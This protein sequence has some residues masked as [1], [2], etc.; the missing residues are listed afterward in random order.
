MARVRVNGADLEVETFGDVRWPAILLIAGSNSSM[1]GWEPDFCRRLAAGPRFVIRYDH[2][3]TGGSTT[4]PA[5]RP[6]Y[7]SRELAQDALGVLD[8]LGVARAHL[9]GVSMGGAIAQL[10]ALDHPD[11][12]VALTLIATSSG[13][14]RIFPRWRRGCGPTS[15]A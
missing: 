2:R 1:D 6:G 7:H 8:A 12:V 15:P 10:L 11:R 3:D 5:G 9:V 4:W 13:P 14:A